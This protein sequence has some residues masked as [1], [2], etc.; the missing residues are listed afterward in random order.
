MAGW[1]ADNRPSTCQCVA[2][3]QT[4]KPIWSD[5]W[6]Q[7]TAVGADTGRSALPPEPLFLPNSGPYQLPIRSWSRRLGAVI[8]SGDFHLGR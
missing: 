3:R 8:L 2:G 5:Y 1:C 6:R 7:W 4:Q